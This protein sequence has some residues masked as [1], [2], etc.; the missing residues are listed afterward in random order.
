VFFGK[1]ANKNN[2]LE[3]SG[4]LL[5]TVAARCLS[6]ALRQFAPPFTKNSEKGTVRATVIRA[7]H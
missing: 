6:D 1:K 4:H 3:V 2:D 5:L 7:T